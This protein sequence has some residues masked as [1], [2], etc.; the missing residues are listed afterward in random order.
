MN[1]EP[2]KLEKAGKAMNSAGKEI[3]WW[4]VCLL[5]LVFVALPLIFH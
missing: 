2:N 5:F 3:F 1:R 4:G